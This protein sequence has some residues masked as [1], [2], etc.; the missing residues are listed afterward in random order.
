MTL[1]AVVLA[2]GL[3]YINQGVVHTAVSH[4]TVQ[5]FA[6]NGELYRKFG[7][8]ELDKE[9]PFS[10]HTRASH[11][12]MSL[13]PYQFP[14]WWQSNIG[15]MK[16]EEADKVDTLIWFKGDS[17]QA[18]VDKLLGSGFFTITSVPGTQINIAHRVREDMK[19]Y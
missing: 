9:K 7:Q 17:D 3:S 5:P 14:V 19:D 18:K 1:Q 2:C 13:Y 11:G 8:Q 15:V 6:R 12:I 16:E 10:G 4:W